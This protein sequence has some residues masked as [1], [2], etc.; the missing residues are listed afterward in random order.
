MSINVVQEGE[1]C[2]IAIDGEMN[3]YTAAEM[4]PA[5]LEPFAGADE[6]EV[7]LEGVS[8]ID[9]AGVQLLITAKREASALNKS[10]RL[11]GHSQPV[12]DVFE[13]CNLSGFFGD[14]LVI[15][16]RRETGGERP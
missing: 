16:S 2:R 1:R 7:S 13:L 5:L 8:E 3:I 4:K 9:T 11:V 6:V 12:V 14:P 15:R 10:L